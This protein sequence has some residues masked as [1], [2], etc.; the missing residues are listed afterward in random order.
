MIKTFAHKGLE[1]FFQ[2]E[3]KRGLNARHLPRLA[4]LLDRLQGAAE[5]RDMNLPGYAL[6]R[7]KGDRKDIWSVKVSGNWRLT[8]RFEDGHAYDVGL[9]D[10]H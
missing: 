9:E 6:H 7:L 8:F 4:R 5:P 1:R 3:E 2:Y 10:Y